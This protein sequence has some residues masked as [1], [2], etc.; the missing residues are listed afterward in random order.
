M[1]DFAIHFLTS[2]WNCL[3]RKSKSASKKQFSNK[4]LFLILIILHSYEH[5]LKVLQSGQKS[6]K[7]VKTFSQGI[8]INFNLFRNKTNEYK[9][10]GCKT[11]KLITRGRKTSKR[12]T[13]RCKTLVVRPFNVIPL[14]ARALDIRT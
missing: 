5:S 13:H 10:S 7:M 14:N 9:T 1:A 11:A 4:G 6:L 8:Q 3:A 12:K 2:Y